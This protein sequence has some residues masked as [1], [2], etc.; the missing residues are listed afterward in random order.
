VNKSLFKTYAASL[1][2]YQDY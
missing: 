2:T 1:A